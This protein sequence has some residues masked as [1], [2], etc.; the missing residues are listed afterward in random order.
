M[1][2]IYTKAYSRILMWVFMNLIHVLPGLKVNILA[3]NIIN[4]K[5]NL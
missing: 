5:K 2:F 3:L 1:C 4:F